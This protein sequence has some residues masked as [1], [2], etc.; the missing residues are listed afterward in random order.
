MYKIAGV[1]MNSG[2]S[3][4]ENIDRAVQ[5]AELAISKGSKIILFGEIF[6]CPWILDEFAQQNYFYSEKVPGPSTKPFMHLAKKYKVTFVCPVM[7]ESDVDGV[8]YNTAVVIS[9]NG[10]I[11]GMHRKIHLPDIEGW[12]EKSYFAK[13]DLGFQ[14][15]RSEWANFGILLSWDNFFPEA[16]RVLAL[17]G[18]NL[19]LCPTTSAFDSQ[20]IWETVI[21]ANSIVNNVFSFRLNRVGS[22]K[23]LDFYGKSFCS[24]PFGELLFIPSTNSEGIVI[25]EI[26]SCIQKTIRS[27]W[28]FIKERSPAD[29]L[30]IMP[31]SI[32]AFWE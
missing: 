20:N 8:Y 18:A 15:F 2:P 9:E 22:E 32:K 7:E 16:A 5:L 24:N 30:P 21:K 17:K 27:D 6:S 3:K 29:Y 13:G 11:S 4:E 23:G 10:E 19:I 14:V 31:K 25:A 12:R 1:Q 26:A 28:S